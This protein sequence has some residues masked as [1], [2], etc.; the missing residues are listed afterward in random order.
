MADGLNGTVVRSPNYISNGHWM[1]HKSEVMNFDM[2]FDEDLM[3]EYLGND[4]RDLSD[5]V[6]ENIQRECPDKKW[7]K[8]SWEYHSPVR[9][10]D[11]EDDFEDDDYSPEEYSAWAFRHIETWNGIREQQVKNGEIL[12]INSVYV[13]LFHIDSH[14]YADST[15]SPTRLGK[16]A[17]SLIV[18]PMKIDK[19]PEFL[20]DIFDSLTQL[21]IEDCNVEDIKREQES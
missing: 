18:M 9:H 15:R 11:F 13:K 16:N 19:V 6:M 5:S 12:F 10:K 4:I 3:K 2:F 14:V 8:T 17:I 21:N 1:L 20:K 7:V